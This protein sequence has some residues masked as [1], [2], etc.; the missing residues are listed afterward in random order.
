MRQRD[1]KTCHDSLYQALKDTQK[2]RSWW[3]D[4]LEKDDVLFWRT[5]KNNNMITEAESAFSVSASLG[6][7]NT[8]SVDRQWYQSKFEWRNN[9]LKSQDSH[10][11]LIKQNL[12]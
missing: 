10:Q 9:K 2:T 8:W 7:E 3:A 11:F 1:V 5:T 4:E 12:D 6:A